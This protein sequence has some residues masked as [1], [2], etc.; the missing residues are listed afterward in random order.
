MLEHVP[1]ECL[2]GCWWIEAR[3]EVMH[4][5]RDPEAPWT[6]VIANSDARRP[7]QLPSRSMARA[8]NRS[9]ATYGSDLPGTRQASIH[10]FGHVAFERPLCA[11]SRRTLDAC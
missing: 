5:G 2:A 6:P 1:T 4:V 9:R 11:T 10:R 7:D 3:T 8:L